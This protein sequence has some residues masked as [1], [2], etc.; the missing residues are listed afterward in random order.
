M[1]DHAAAAVAT[2]RLARSQEAPFGERVVKSKRCAEVEAQEGE[3]QGNDGK[4]R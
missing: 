2:S 1:K 4:G 3:I